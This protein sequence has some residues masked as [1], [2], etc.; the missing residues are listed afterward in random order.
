MNAPEHRLASEA[1]FS[2]AS[3]GLLS[4]QSK[5]AISAQWLQWLGELVPGVRRSFVLLDNG[6]GT[7][8]SCA[9]LPAGTNPEMS[10]PLVMQAVTQGALAMRTT[11]A[12]QELAVPLRVAGHIRGAVGVE[13]TNPD[14]AA[15]EHACT[16]VH[17]GLG[18][19]RSALGGVADARN[20]E[21]LARARQAIELSLMVTAEPGFQS[22]AMAVANQLCRRLECDQVQLGWLQRGSTKLVARSNS[23]WHDGRAN[24]V[25]LAEQAMDESLDQGEA[26]TLPALPQPRLAAALANEAYRRSGIAAATMTVP[27]RANG[28]IVGALLFERGTPFVETEVDGVEALGLML[29]PL[30]QLKHIGDE[31]VAQHARR[32]WA[33]LGGWLTGSRHLGWKL[34]GACVVVLLLLAAV[35]PVTHRV[36]APASVEGQ[37]QRVA[38]A[39]FAGYIR[40]AAARAGDLVK[41]G[42][43]LARLDDK[44]L[45]LERSRWQSELEVALRKEREAMAGGDRVAMRLSAAQA[46]Q[47]QAQLDLT[48]EKLQRIEITAPFDAVVV[49]GD[50]SQQ[51]GSPVEMG[52]AL[53]ELAPLE[54]WRIILK[55]D[56]RDVA[57]LQAG[58][59]G[60]L[61]LASLP[62]QTFDLT[63][64]RVLSVAVAEEGRNFFRVEAGLAAA[65]DASKA[66]PRLRPGME[67]VAKVAVGEA[68]LLWVWTHRLTDWLRR[69]AWEWTP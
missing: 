10:R 4:A 58:Q 42:Q 35:V 19:L 57:W 38:A 30:L 55:V 53:F 22:A 51:I 11:P 26:V 9:V 65:A 60:E 13:L 2:A 18:W 25:R 34:L 45:T 62:G 27:L 31:S 5:E 15:L 43:V 44:D 61:V 3:H 29:A 24:L 66:S 50:L 56:E 69:T 16:A 52:K 39:P 23:A 63:A 67:G 48:E 47:A 46:A 1:T 33:A 59:R 14:A 21:Q 49:K 8:V 7:L 6:S 36:T 64:Q 17:W 20:T 54:A 28:E 41:A 68:P 37:T 40:S 12:G 32:R